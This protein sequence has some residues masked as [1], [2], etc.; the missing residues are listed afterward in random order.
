MRKLFVAVAD[1]EEI[2][3]QQRQI[4]AAMEDFEATAVF[5]HLDQN[6][7]GYITVHELSSFLNSTGTT[8]VSLESLAFMVKYFDSM[9]SDKLNM[10]DFI[11]ILLPCAN[12]YLRNRATN[13]KLHHEI[14]SFSREVKDQLSALIQKEWEFHTEVELI[15]K[16]IS[17]SSNYNAKEL[18][19]AI[20]VKKN[21][22][23]DDQTI[24]NFLKNQGFK[25]SKQDINSI[26]RRFDVTA[27]AKISYNEFLEGVTPSNAQAPKERIISK[28]DLNYKNVRN[29]LQKDPYTINQ[30]RIEDV[31]PNKELG[32]PYRR[33][34]YG[35]F[36]NREE[37]KRRDNISSR[38][39]EDNR[40]Y[41]G[42]ERPIQYKVETEETDNFRCQEQKNDYSPNYSRYNARF[43][44]EI[45]HRIVEDSKNMKEGK[46]PYSR[47]LYNL[48]TKSYGAQ[49]EIA[50]YP[51]SSLQYRSSRESFKAPIEPFRSQI[52]NRERYSPSRKLIRF[53]GEQQDISRNRNWQRCERGSFIE[54]EKYSPLNKEKLEFTATYNHDFYNKIDGQRNFYSKNEKLETNTLENNENS[55]EKTQY[56]QYNKI[57]Y[58]VF[59]GG[60]SSMAPVNSLKE[61]ENTSKFHNPSPYNRYKNRQF[62]EESPS[63]YQLQQKSTRYQFSSPERYNSGKYEKYQEWDSQYRMGSCIDNNLYSNYKRSESPDRFNNSK[64]YEKYSKYENSATRRPRSEYGRSEVGQEIDRNS[65]YQNHTPV[66]DVTKTTPHYSSYSRG[67]YSHQLNA[68]YSSYVPRTASEFLANPTQ[69]P[70]INRPSTPKKISWVANPNESGEKAVANTPNKEE[71]SGSGAFNM[72]VSPEANSNS[73]GWSFIPSPDI[74]KKDSAVDKKI[75]DGI[76]KGPL[77]L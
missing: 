36:N 30:A 23:L 3:E 18:F 47:D 74:K 10:N 35:E 41:Q 46:N 5:L 56:G 39:L 60:Y 6:K 16:E 28:C 31:R 71:K 27:D 29:H 32:S 43:G 19:S 51:T 21:N 40:N 24:E 17:N 69:V 65:I 37:N 66:R 73:G 70:D 34:N 4:L 67:G 75:L 20:D 64:F 54:G 49:Q 77:R 33:S 52:Q 45:P 68:K 57:E 12:D 63:R 48:N 58:P 7:K 53:E 11:Q 61:G 44:E 55:I 15:K 50:T 14:D 25:A 22:F 62:N 1:R 26:I 72:I 38:Y 59:P 2:T 42:Y 9:E 13:R 76:Q 8:D